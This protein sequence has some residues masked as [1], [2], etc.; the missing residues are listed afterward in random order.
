MYMNNVYIDTDKLSEEIDKIKKVNTKL[1]EIFS[2]IK[3]SFWNFKILTSNH[4]RETWFDH[5]TRTEQIVGCV[6]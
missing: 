5:P 2:Q 4:V 1:E 6:R 3:G